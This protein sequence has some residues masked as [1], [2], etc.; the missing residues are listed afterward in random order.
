[1]TKE[2]TG[3]PTSAA[4]ETLGDVCW[5]MAASPAHKHMFIGDL[6]RLVAPA[7][8][9][10]QF[11]LYR[12]DKSPWAYAGWAFLTEAAEQRLTS[13]QRRLQPAEWRA[14]DRLWLTD[15]V[16]PFGGA[17]GVLKDIRNTVFPDRSVKTLVPGEDGK[18]MRVMVLRGRELG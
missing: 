4:A 10:K 11:H 15:L 9:H 17:E 7:V 1:M 8:T 3:V 5:L 16:A 12:T 18:G 13:G 14:G 6:D 2:A